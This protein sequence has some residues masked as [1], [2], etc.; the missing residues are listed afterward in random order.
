MFLYR[1][2]EFILRFRPIQVGLGSNVKAPEAGSNEFNNL[3][4]RFGGLVADK[5]TDAKVNGFDE[6]VITDFTK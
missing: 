3:A 4:D 1:I 2:H 5:L 6:V